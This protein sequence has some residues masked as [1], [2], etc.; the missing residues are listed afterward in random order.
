ML[1]VKE[2]KISCLISLGKILR[3]EKKTRC[4]SP[5]NHGTSVAI[6]WD[7]APIPDSVLFTFSSGME[8]GVQLQFTPKCL[9]QHAVTFAEVQLGR[10]G[11]FPLDTFQVKILPVFI[12]ACDF[13]D[14]EVVLPFSVL[15]GRIR[16]SQYLPLTDLNK[17]KF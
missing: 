15:M 3:Q 11:L 12:L 10:G 2:K 16:S 9:E 5:E 8:A 17:I 4:A 13:Y 14:L 1:K 6:L 7:T